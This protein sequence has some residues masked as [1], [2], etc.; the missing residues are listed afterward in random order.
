MYKRQLESATG[1]E[2]KTVVTVNDYTREQDF[3]AALMV[4]DQLG[5]PG[6]GFTVLA[7]DAGDAEYVDVAFL[8][9]LFR[10]PSDRDSRPG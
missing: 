3:S 2:V 10:Q 5:E 8:K 6:A 4:L 1:A 7:G 9:R